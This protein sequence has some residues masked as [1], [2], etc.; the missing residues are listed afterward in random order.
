MPLHIASVTADV[1]VI[2]GEAPLSDRHVAQVANAM[3]Q[4]LAA[5]ERDDRRQHEATCIARSAQPSSPVRG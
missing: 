1:T 2:D 3:I 5:K 4:L